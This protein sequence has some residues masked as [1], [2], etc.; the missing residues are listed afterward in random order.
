MPGGTPSRRRPPRP[1]GVPVLA[2]VPA[3][4][5]LDG[6]LLAALAGLTA[7]LVWWRPLLDLDIAVRDWCD[8]R[9]PPP[10]S[11]IMWFFDHLGQGG[12]L[13]TVT[14]AVSFWLAW[15]HR[16][17]RPIIPAGLA[18][19]IST[20]LIVGLKRWTS[21]GAP[22]HGSVEMFSDGWEEYYPSGHVSNGIVY[23]GVLAMLLAP[24]LPVLVRR[25]L[26]WLPGVLTFIGTTYLGYHWLTDSIGGYLLGLLIVRLLLRVPWRTMP[27]PRWLDR[28]AARERRGSTG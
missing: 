2:P 26:Q 5:W 12:I 8:A 27:L 22:H 21:R 10:V 4:W 24:Y 6:V 25:V 17:V 13:T 9:R 23:Y 14:V 3:G 1:L 7:A 18:P 11:G 20:V 19:I 16:S 15:R 28:S